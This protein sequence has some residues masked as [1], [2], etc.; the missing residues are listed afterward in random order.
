MD[1]ERCGRSC[2]PGVGNSSGWFTSA[3]GQP[4]KLVAKWNGSSWSALGSGV[5]VSFP[6]DGVFR[7]EVFDDGDGPALY[8]GGTFAIAGGALAS[9]IARWDGA[10]WKPL[11]SGVIGQPT[12]LRAFDDGSDASPDL[13]VGGIG[14]AGSQPASGIARWSGCAVST[15]PTPGLV[16]AVTPAAWQAPVVEWIRDKPPHDAVAP[17]NKVDYL[18]D[19][20]GDAAF[21]IIVNLRE[22]DQ[23]DVLAFI[24]ATSPGATI[25]RLGRYI[26]FIMASGC[27]K[28]EVLAIA[29]HPSVAFI[30]RQIDFEENLDISVPAIKVTASP[31]H[32]PNTVQDA[33]PG[34]DG[35]G[36]TIAI[37]DTGVDNLQHQAFSGM[38]F[39]AGY[40]AITQTLVDP[41]DVRGHGTHVAAIALGRAF[42][43]GSAGV[44]PGAGLVDVKVLNDMGIGFSTWTFD[45]V[46]TIYDNR[47][48]W[49]VGV[50][51]LS[52]GNKKPSDGTEAICQ[53]INLAETMGICVVC[54]AGNNGPNN[55]SLGTP[56]SAARALTVAASEDADTITRGD[57]SIA[58]F[59]SR[60][61]RD[62]N[63]NASQ[64]DELKPELCAPGKGIFAAQVDT[65]SGIISKSGTS[66]AAPHV[67]GV[68]ALLRQAYPGLNPASIRCR[69]ID[70][71]EQLAGYS[72]SLPNI[73]PVW[74]EASGWGLVDAWAAATLATGTDVRFPSHPP[75]PPWLSPDIWIVPDPAVAGQVTAVFAN[76]FN[77]SGASIPDVLVQFGVHEYAA[78]N[79]TFHDIGSVVVTLDPGMN[80]VTLGGW[81][82]AAASH[83]CLKVAIGYC[84]DP[85]GSNNLA[86]RN[87]NVAKS[88]VTF[89]VRNTLTLAPA[90][91]HF[92]VAAADPGWTVEITPPELVLAGDE[93]PVEVVVLPI[94]APGTPAGATTRID[95]GAWIGDVLLGG[96]SIL[97]TMK[98]CNGNGIADSLDLLD[99]SSADVDANGVP[100]ECQCAGD[101]N[102]DG[103]VDGADLGL[104][105]GSWGQNG[106]ADLDGSQLVDGADL[107]LLLG[108][109]GD[110]R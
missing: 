104:L 83:Q 22:C 13:Y 19:E 77:P 85:D 61:P 12:A 20:S 79:P 38:P 107:G 59:S 66:M 64:L 110:C 40:N 37:I 57:D 63:G 91:I 92:E 5:G 74:N 2:P 73:D 94:P 6:P 36:V 32:S 21:D 28:Q 78:A 58:S 9:N 33:L 95:I 96:V 68:I 46:E 89:Q 75:Q 1:A 76:I 43:G 4:A 65:V 81:V 105:L 50:M 7:M 27:T 88:P 15:T 3:G 87:L 70:T 53:L 60:G 55:F 98:D 99:G 45:G 30:E 35:T 10:S 25:Q 48:A 42:A 11:G 16:F 97:A 41:D 109:W 90:T 103:V 54:S 100:D 69:L 29:A 49:N 106:A 51:N 80:T 18:I 23:G 72:A 102:A 84:A 101:I 108:A 86:Q 17:F 31:Q 39:V 14:A 8:V 62:N 34:I 26:T 82:P 67:A 71:A 24:E 93:C 56:A 47:Q 44:A 52:L